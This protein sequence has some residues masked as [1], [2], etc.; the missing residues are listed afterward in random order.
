MSADASRY[1]STSRPRPPRYTLSTRDYE[2]GAQRVLDDTAD[3]EL[4]A[5]WLWETCKQAMMRPATTERHL[6]LRVT[7]R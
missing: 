2:S 1:S 7:V 5:R 4:A 3:E 6:D